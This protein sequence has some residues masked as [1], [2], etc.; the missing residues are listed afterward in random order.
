MK[1][2]TYIFIGL[3]LG[4]LPLSAQNTNI[5]KAFKI[6]LILRIGGINEKT[7]ELGLLHYLE[8]LMSFYTSTKDPDA[9]KNQQELNDL[10]CE[11]NAF[12]GDDTCGYHIEGVK[13]NQDRLIELMLNNYID[14]VIDKSII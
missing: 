6:E 13:K 14:P 11:T 10:G 1:T 7:K 4:S 3:M 2:Y 5:K 9:K 12:T 8:H